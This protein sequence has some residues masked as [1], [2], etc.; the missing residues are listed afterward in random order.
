MNPF[1][2]VLI[3]YFGLSCLPVFCCAQSGSVAAPAIPTYLVLDK[4]GLEN[5]IRFY[6]GETLRFRLREEP[7]KY[8]GKL[9]GVTPRTILILNTEIPLRDIES[10]TY[11]K[12]GYWAGFAKLTRGSL[13][14]GSVMLALMGTIN[15]L[16]P[17]K[18]SPPDATL[19]KLSPIALGLSFAIKPLYKRTYEL[20][21][22]RRLRT[23]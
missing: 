10:I 23:I 5:R 16:K 12:T 1:W 14:S 22:K 7:G 9:Q 3:F 4:P 11:Q 17:P 6:P 8:I 20:N 19:L 15:Y 2:K 13:L 18:D 21:A